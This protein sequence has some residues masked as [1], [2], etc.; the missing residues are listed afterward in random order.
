MVDLSGSGFF[1]GCD[2]H[3]YKACHKL[4]ANILIRP[5]LDQPLDSQG[6]RLLS[7]HTVA[8][9]VA[10]AALAPIGANILY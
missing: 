6:L 2:V 9:C 10:K 4:N 1:F 5:E 3:S 8:K 7:V